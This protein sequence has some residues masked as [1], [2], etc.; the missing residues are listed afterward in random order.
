MGTQRTTNLTHFAP[1]PDKYVGCIIHTL[2]TRL[3]L[4][5]PGINTFSGKAMLGKTEMFLEQ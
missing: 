1:K 2:A 5:T 4:G 3:Q